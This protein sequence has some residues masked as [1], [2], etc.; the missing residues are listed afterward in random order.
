MTVRWHVSFGEGRKHLVTIST[1]VETSPPSMA[2][3]GRA[4]GPQLAV[5]PRLLAPRNR[6]S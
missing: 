1:A 6:A 3:R 2:D 4:Y 5:A